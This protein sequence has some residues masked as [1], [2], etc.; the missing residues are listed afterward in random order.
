MQFLH[1]V[2]M[3]AKKGMGATKVQTNFEDLEREAEMADSLRSQKAAEAN[4][5]EEI[6]SQVR[7]PC[8]WRFPLL[9]R[10]L[11]SFTY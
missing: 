1:P 8:A 6:E 10:R 7:K 4:K 2:Q 11:E 3:G 5:P 9:H